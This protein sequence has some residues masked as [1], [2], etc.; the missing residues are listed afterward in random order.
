RIE[1]R[2]PGERRVADAMRAFKGLRRQDVPQERRCSYYCDP[3]VLADHRSAIEAA[4][5][6]LG[7]DVLYSADHYLD[8]LPPRTDKGRTLTALSRQ[9]KVAREHVLVA[10]D[11]LNALSMYEAGFRGVC[12]GGCESA[13]L[14]ATASR[15][16]VLHARAPG[17]GGILEAI[18]HFD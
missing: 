8:I 7:C 12:V 6:E 1:E 14:S 10:G 5:R 9:L 16:Q 13:L 4:A 18:D 3:D 17:C 15:K 2:W 11:T